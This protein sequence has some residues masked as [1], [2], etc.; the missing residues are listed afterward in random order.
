[1]KVAIIGC[2][3]MG[4]VHAR[5]A[6]LAGFRVV[7]CGDVIRAKA[8]SLANRI[9]AEATDDCLGLIRKEGIDIVAIT[10][11]TPQHVP[12][13]IAAA[14]A[15][16][17]V[18]CEKPLGRTVEECQ[19]AVRV[20]QKHRVKLYVGH[21]V[22]FFQEFERIRSVVLS[23]RIGK[24]GFVKTY[25]GG[26]FPRGEGLWFRD[27][28]QSGG[29]T[30]DTII[31]DFDWI[32]YMWGDPKRVF[33]QAL[34]RGDI[35]D[36]SL[37]TLRM[38][39]DVLAHVIGTWAHPGGFR[40]KVEV[41]GDKGMVGY[42]SNEAPIE[43]MKRESAGGQPGMIVPGSPVPVSPYQLEWEDF[44]AWLEGKTSPRVTAEDAVWA[45]K[46]SL[47]ALES[48]KTKEPVVF[49]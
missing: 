27:Y 2:G 32:R 35:I 33:C 43:S 39:N 40:V 1:M 4:A 12:F 13:V 7:A 30:L 46:I 17:H 5:V 19:E 48:A 47:A 26:I 6:S 9:G 21:V 25:R 44:R 29:V 34:L 42:D 23:G 11:P 22:R 8:E 38:K 20:A 16:K 49:N 45:V 10:T 31:H 24:V 37:V 28:A 15:G 36:Y 3:G 41:C 14:E 18:F